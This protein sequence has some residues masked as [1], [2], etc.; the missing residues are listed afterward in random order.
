[1]THLLDVKLDKLDFV[2]W[3]FVVLFFA[4]SAYFFQGN[5]QLTIIGACA[6]IVLMMAISHAIELILGALRNNPRAGE[7][8]GYITNGPEALCVIVGLMSN[9]LLFAVGVPLGSNFANPVLLALAAV[10]THCFYK[11]LEKNA[12]KNFVIIIGTMALAGSFYIVPREFT[13]LLIWALASLVLSIL[14]YTMK[15]SEDEVDE[16]VDTYPLLSMI[17]AALVL[18]GAGYF[19]DPAVSFTASNSKVPE[20]AI[21]FFVLSFISSWPEFRSALTLLRLG[22]IQSALVNIFV[23]NITNLWLGV[24]G[25]LVYL[26]SLR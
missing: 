5:M 10:L 15:G 7:F 8:T 17:P 16:D 6:I 18:V 13:P 19:L 20:G 12:L 24:A 1:M 3:A 4:V 11:L 9:K 14:F 23:S 22:R 21:G 25:V 26:L 2:S